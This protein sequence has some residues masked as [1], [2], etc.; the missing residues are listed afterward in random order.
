MVNVMKHSHSSPK[1]YIIILLCYQMEKWHSLFIQI[2]FFRVV[3]VGLE[4]GVPSLV[5][6]CEEVVKI[7]EERPEEDKEDKE[8]KNE[9]TAS[10]NKILSNCK[11][12]ILPNK[13]HL[14][15]FT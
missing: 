9:E 1:I 15:S 8:T 4:S 5:F 3:L 11:Q 6:R 14:T 13:V 2:D 10:G 12:N 7:R